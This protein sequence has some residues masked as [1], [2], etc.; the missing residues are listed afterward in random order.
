MARH[1]LKEK[2][3]TL[4]VKTFEH[5]RISQYYEFNLFHSLLKSYHVVKIEVKTNKI[6]YKQHCGQISFSYHICTI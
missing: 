4:R 6:G 3:F 2:I 1:N 5:L